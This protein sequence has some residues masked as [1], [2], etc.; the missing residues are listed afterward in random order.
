MPRYDGPYMIIDTDNKHSTVT[1]DLPNAPNIFPTYHS[2]VVLPYIENDAT[3]FPGREFSKPDPIT[4]E[5]G[6]K[7]Y[8]VC[9]IIDECKQGHGYQYLVRWVGYGPEEDRWISGSELNDTEALDIWLAK[10]RGGKLSLSTSAS[11]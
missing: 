5:D 10:A 1:V 8:Y 7:E 3:L 4:T 6:D 11:W 9:D 2:S